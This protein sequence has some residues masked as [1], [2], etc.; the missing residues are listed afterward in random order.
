MNTKELANK[1]AELLAAKEKATMP[2]NNKGYEW[3]YN[4]LSTFYQD[5]VLKT[6][7]PK[8]RLAEIKKEGESLHEQYEREQE[9]A[10]QFKKRIKIMC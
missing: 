10:N 4:Q 1:Y 2:P 3:K 8:E 9:E 5:A 7:L 6:K